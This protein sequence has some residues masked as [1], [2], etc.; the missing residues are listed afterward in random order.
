MKKLLILSI[1][2]TIT[3]STIFCQS[4]NTI[5]WKKNYN[6][7]LKEYPQLTERTGNAEYLIA[8]MFENYLVHRERDIY[9]KKLDVSGEI[10]WQKEIGT[11]NDDIPYYVGKDQQ[12]YYNLIYSGFEPT[13]KKGIIHVVKFDETGKEKWDREFYGHDHESNIH[14][15]QFED[16]GFL[17]AAVK[18]SKSD[19]DKDIWLIKLDKKGKMEWQ[20]IIRHRYSDEVAFDLI[21]YMGGEGYLIAGYS[22]PLSHEKHDGYIVKVTDRGII[23]W[24]KTYGEDEIDKI[25]Q[26][27]QLGPNEF[28]CI[29]T[30]RSYG[31][32]NEKIW[33]MKVDKDGNE[34]WKKL[35]GNFIGSIDNVRSYMEGD[36]IYITSTISDN[37]AEA[38][39]GYIL[40]LTTSGSLLWED[41]YIHEDL[42]KITNILQYKGDNFTLMSTLSDSDKG[43]YALYSISVNP[44]LAQ[45]NAF[46]EEKSTVKQPVVEAQAPDTRPVQSNYN[47][48][49]SSNPRDGKYIA[50]I[51]AVSQY[52]DPRLPDLD[53]P[54]QDAQ[55]LIDILVSDYTFNSED[56]I[57]LKNP[58]RADIITALDNLEKTVTPEDNLLI[59]YAGH[60]YWDESTEKGYWLPSDAEQDN[61]ANWFRN[62]SLSSYI[63]GIKSNH[64]LLIADACFSGGIFKTRSAMSSTSKAVERLYKLNSRKA[65][66][67][68]T[69][70]EVPDNSIFMRYLLKRL[71]ENSETF[72]PS[73]L[74]FFSFKTAVLN[75]SQNI[76]QFGVIK[77][78]GDE[79]GDFIFVKRP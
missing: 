41:L 23:E 69:L 71:K 20:S 34:T 65:M 79:G 18:V 15:H 16:G 43:R 49:I 2:S 17:I 40:S 25:Y 6:P 19:H 42:K 21:P 22:M 54:E 50:L 48:M 58:K 28:M 14:C 24:E 3:C 36:R 75:N 31:V 77:D 53:Q 61:T 47:V 72:L 46:K 76:P 37:M 51:I 55:A 11:E 52:D 56:I 45:R 27:E 64:T 5:L 9:I 73:E 29:G 30:T 4:A 7:S 60:G 8:G 62:T 35:Y 13:T 78:T 26:F 32:K 59:F 74:L 10:V 39:T 12:G 44:E 63:S 67:S 66:T 38:N 57:F 70:K 1:L 68:G 33:L